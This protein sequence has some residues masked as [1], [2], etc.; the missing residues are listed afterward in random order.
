MLYSGRHS[1]ALVK[2]YF[3]TFGVPVPE[4]TGRKAAKAGQMQSLMAAVDEATS[5]NEP[6]QDWSV[7]ETPP[8]GAASKTVT[9]EVAVQPEAAPQQKMVSAPGKPSAKLAQMLQDL[10]PAQRDEAAAVV[11]KLLAIRAREAWPK[12]AA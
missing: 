9:P 3:E 11:A 7:F 12:P 5:N 10:T 2:L 6:I 8:P 4:A 1:E